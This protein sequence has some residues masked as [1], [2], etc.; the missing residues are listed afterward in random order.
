MSLPRRL[1]IAFSG[2]GLLAI[3]SLAFA[4][5]RQDPA[6]AVVVIQD[7]DDDEP[8]VRRPGFRRE[9]DDPPSREETV[10]FLFG[11]SGGFSPRKGTAWKVQY[12]RGTHKGLY[13]TGAWFKRSLEEDWIKVLEDARMADLFVP[14]HQSSYTRYFDLTG[15]SFPL[16]RVQQEDAGP[17]G[18]L[19][20]PFEGDAYPRVVKEIRDRGVA[21]KDWGNGVRRGKEMVL[22]S[23][24]QAGNYMYIMQYGF[25]DDGTITFRSGATGQNLPGARTEAHMHNTHWRI[26]IDLIDG[27]KNNAMVM[28]HVE[29]PQSLA[30]EDIEEP[31]NGGVEGG[32]DWDPKEFTMLRVETQSKNPNGKTIAYDLMPFRWGSSRH[33]EAFTQH[34]L[35]VSKAHPDRPL[36]KVFDNLPAT[37]RDKETVEETDVVLWVTTS[38]HH[39]PRDEDGKGS[40][41]TRRQWYYDDG[42]EGSALVMWS[43][44]DLRPRNLFDRTP[45]YPY[46]PPAVAPAPAPAPEVAP[47]TEPSAGAR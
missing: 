13:I 32:I 9:L 24:L 22:W 33:N 4:L 26:D 11:D 45:F 3:G 29:D 14:Y 1:L 40:G 39:E 16:A 43:G 17:T 21:W 15:F 27:A 5:P 34:D 42:W 18:S 31:F 37:V 6:P 47:E 44:F 2:I 25:Q 30:A 41:R 8:V 10:E 28:R 38:A 36:E 20:P 7:D 46:A 35:W 12:A 19:L 23:G